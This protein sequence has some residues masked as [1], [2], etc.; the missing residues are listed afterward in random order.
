MQVGGDLGLERPSLDCRATSDLGLS[1]AANVSVRSEY[2]NSVSWA[3]V[4]W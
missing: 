4:A 1:T 2:E 3:G